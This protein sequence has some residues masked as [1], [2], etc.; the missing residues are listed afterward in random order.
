MEPDVEIAF[1]S[2]SWHDQYI[3]LR[4]AINS[5]IPARHPKEL[6]FIFY[7]DR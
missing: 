1:E 2:C 3:Y 5:S 7:G 4:T 6:D